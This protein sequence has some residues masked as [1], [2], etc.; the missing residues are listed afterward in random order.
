MSNSY[1]AESATFF[2]YGEPEPVYADWTDADW[3]SYDAYL[4]AE[5]DKWDA[6]YGAEFYEG[7]PPF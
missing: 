7:E 1:D 2:G 3:A 5:Q 6:E 4:A